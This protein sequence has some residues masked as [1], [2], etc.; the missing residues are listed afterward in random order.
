MTQMTDEE[1]LGEV[2]SWMQKINEKLDLKLDPDRLIRTGGYNKHTRQAA[3][4]GGSQDPD[5]ES[6]SYAKVTGRV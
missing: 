3:R 2:K 1:F 6:L 4:D 5:N